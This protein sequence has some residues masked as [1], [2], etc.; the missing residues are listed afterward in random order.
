MLYNDVTIGGELYHYGVKGMK[1][2]IRR[3]QP[4][5]S[6][7]KGSTG[8]YIGKQ[9]SGRQYNR[10]NNYRKKNNKYGKNYRND[11]YRMKKNDEFRNKA[12]KTVYDSMKNE[13]QRK[14][15]KAI[16]GLAGAAT[17]GLVAVGIIG[18]RSAV[19]R[20]LVKEGLRAA[21]ADTKT[22]K[23][24]S[25]LRKAKNF[26]KK[27]AGKELIRAGIAAAGSLGLYA[28][29]SAY[30]KYKDTKDA[31][32]RKNRNKDN[33]ESEVKKFAK[34]VAVGA[35][36]G[37]YAALG[38]ETPK[39]QRKQELN[40]QSGTNG[41]LSDN[42]KREYAK[43]IKRQDKKVT[44]RATRIPSP[45]RE[46]TIMAYS[47]ERGESPKY[48]K[49]LKQLNIEKEYNR[50]KKDLEKIQKDID[51]PME[52]A[53]SKNGGLIIRAK[54]PKY[55]KIDTGNTFTSVKSLDDIK[56]IVKL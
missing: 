26:L 32:K 11:D 22:R 45:L 48:K 16:V 27:E 55:R 18:L 12:K 8:R 54:D 23:V 1:W 47:D 40:K 21:T 37:P 7:Y 38:V 24:V 4:Y 5:G 52:I 3:Y 46:K 19:G 31:M 41:W 39:T 51:H 20:K 43:E 53:V 42:E 34:T 56:R 25:G 49:Y 10:N 44:R 15:E 9:G 2:G 36:F 6:G 33:K 35:A 14:K 28:G 50:Y 13:A 30:D 29:L 17:I